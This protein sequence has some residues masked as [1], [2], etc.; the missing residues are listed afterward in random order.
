MFCIEVC[1]PL[2]RSVWNDRGRC[3]TAWAPLDAF[4]FSRF[5]PLRGNKFTREQ[6]VKVAESAESLG[7]RARV[8]P[9]DVIDVGLVKRAEATDIELVTRAETLGGSFRELSPTPSFPCKAGCETC[10]G[11]AIW[12]ALDGLR[13]LNLTGGDK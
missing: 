7:Y 6:A 13:G 9:I 11:A 3:W 1:A 2:P 12:R 5:L 8:R 4:W 10:R